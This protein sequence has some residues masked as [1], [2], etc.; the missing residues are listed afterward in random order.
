MSTTSLKIVLKVIW[1][2]YP[3]WLWCLCLRTRASPSLSTNSLCYKKNS[4]RV[5]PNTWYPRTWKLSTPS[6]ISFTPFLN[7]H[8]TLTLN[9]SFK[10]K[11]RESRDIISG[12]SIRLFWA[13]LKTLWTPWSTEFAVWNKLVIRA[14]LPSLSLKFT[15]NW[16]WR[17][18]NL[19]LLKKRSNSLSIRQPLLYWDVLRNFSIGNNPTLI[20][21]RKPV[22]MKW[23]L[24]TKKLLRSSFCW[25][26]LFKEQR[27]K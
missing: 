19:T 22:S 10:K 4:S 7:T 6:T 3:R 17:R 27:T 14:L 13:P 23:L 8:W 18:L 9:Q 21:T 16:I 12:I 25:L 26:V 11:L 5:E 2:K 20:M 1:N 24:R 15:F